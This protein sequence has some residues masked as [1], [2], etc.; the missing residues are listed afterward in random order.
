MKANMTLPD[1]AKAKEYFQNKISFTIGPMELDHLIKDNE[2]INIVDVRAQEDYEKG[3]IPGALNLPRERWQSLEGLSKD[4]P[5]VL[6]C[7]TMVCHLAATAAVEFAGKGF[8]VKELEGGFD[9]WKED[10][11]EVET[12]ANRR[13]SLKV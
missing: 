8:P 7:Y 12:R 5:N 4:K 9:G 3:H 13:V 1:P 11:L 10:N 6:Y 2:N